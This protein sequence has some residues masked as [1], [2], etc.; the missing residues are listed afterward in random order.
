MN[1]ETYTTAIGRMTVVCALLLAASVSAPAE[2]QGYWGDPQGQTGYMW[3]DPEVGGPYSAGGGRHF[4]V[5][6]GI[7]YYASGS[8]T[9]SGCVNDATGL[10]SAFLEDSSRWSSANITL[11]TDGYATKSNI[12]ASLQEMGQNAGPGDVCVYLQSSH[13]EQSYGTSTYLVTYDDH[14]SDEE[15]GMD[16]ANFFDEQTTVIVIA[17]ACFAGGLFKDKANARAAAEG[18]NSAFVQNVMA[19]YQTAK[20]GSTKS[21]AT[22]SKNLGGNI[23]FITAADYNETS[24]DVT[25]AYVFGAP[26]GLFTGYLLQ[27]FGATET[28]TSGDRQLSFWELYAWAAPRANQGQTAQTFNQPLLNTTIASALSASAQLGGSGQSG[29]DLDAGYAPGACGMMGGFPLFATL[30]A[31]GAVGFSRRSSRRLG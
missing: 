17:D 23:G 29:T 19:A 27:A 10:R 3:P 6:V 5:L 9:L 30:G 15:L 24:S 14:Y 13:G 21:G 22:L 28:D 1:R 26:Q 2:G 11:L 25:A 7:N 16:L 18:L 12:R 4:A 8:N 20:G 31:V